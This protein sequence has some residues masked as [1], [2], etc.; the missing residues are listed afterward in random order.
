M[1]DVKEKP[2]ETPQ[3]ETPPVTQM[4]PDEPN[5]HF[6]QWLD[7]NNYEVVLG[8]LGNGNNP[9]IDGQGFALTDKPVLV[10]TIKKKGNN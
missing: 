1:A 9:Y 6:K 3:T 2:V 4:L 7:L 8:I 10:V 5:A